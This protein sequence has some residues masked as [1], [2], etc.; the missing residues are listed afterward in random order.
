M[1]VA[2]LHQGDAAPDRRG[3][4]VGQ[5]AATRQLRIGHEVKGRVEAAGH[6]IFTPARTVA[7]SSSASSSRSRQRRLPGP[8]ATAAAR[9]PAR[10]KIASARAA[11]SSG[12][13]LDREE[14]ADHRA[15]GA[16]QRGHPGHARIA[17]ADLAP[18]R[19]VGDPVDRAADRN[20]N[21]GGA[22]Q[23]R[24]G[25]DRLVGS[26]RAV[27]AF[28]RPGRGAGQRQDLRRV[29]ADH[30]RPQPDQVERGARA[31]RGGA[32]ADRIEHPRAAQRPRPVRRPRHGGDP[33]WRQGPDVDHQ[34]ARD[35]DEVLDLLL[36]MDHG[37]G[38]AEREQAVRHHVHGDEVGDVMNE[39]RVPTDGFQA[40]PR[41]GGMWHECSLP[42]GEP[43]A[44]QCTWRSG[45]GR[46]YRLPS[47]V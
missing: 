46:P 28:G 24:C 26:M 36:G 6:A 32:S 9:S 44:A 19:A 14:R 13:G 8:A 2:Q 31:V 47:L 35:R 4:D 12:I 34:S 10:P 5:P 30:G 17:I 11:A 7:S 38:G 27:H 18:A 16:P 41:R 29:A 40:R 39:R 1:L 23:L 25:I 33:R 45:P 3:D 20:H 37:G 42:F 21:V 15:R 22:G 43:I